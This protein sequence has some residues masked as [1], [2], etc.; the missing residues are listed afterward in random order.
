MTAPTGIWTGTPYDRATTSDRRRAISWLGRI[1][2]SLCVSGVT[3][4]LS[5][6]I[7]AVLIGFDVT[8]PSTAN[9]IA[10]LVCIGPQFALNRR[11]V[12]MGSGRSHWRREVMP[13]WGY[14]LISLVLST[15]AVARAGH[16]ADSIGASPEQR[17]MITLGANILTYGTLWMGQFLLLD[18]VLFRHHQAAQVAM[19][20]GG[21]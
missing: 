14:S 21:V 10:A 11:W 19:A 4:V 7:L 18:K 17:T 9:V 6:T 20:A 12:W 13:F 1:F 3:T 8:A 15:V 16:W 2:R 5:L